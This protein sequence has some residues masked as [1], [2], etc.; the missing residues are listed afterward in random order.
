[1]E[2]PVKL[3]M[4][5]IMGWH[6]R[7][8]IIQKADYIIKK[9]K[10]KENDNITKNTEITFSLRNARVIDKSKEDDI[11]LKIETSE[12]KNYIKLDSLNE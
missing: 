5:M 6:K 3:W 4:G 8:M 2:Y 1:M 12:Y 11:V 7:I 10:K 9:R